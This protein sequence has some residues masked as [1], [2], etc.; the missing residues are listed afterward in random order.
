MLHVN[1]L[2]KNFLGRPILKNITYNFPSTGLIGLVGVNGAGKTTFLNILCGLD[3]PDSGTIGQTKSKTLGYLPQEVNINPKST[4]IEECMS[5]NT[6]LYQLK[7]QL[8][9][10]NLILSDCYTDEYYNKFETFENKYRNAGGYAFEANASKV[11][12]GLG[13]N[14]EQ[15]NDHPKSLSGG[16]RMRL[17]LAKVLIKNPDFLILD[18]PTNHLDLPSIIW[19]EAYLKKI[20]GTVL[21]VSHDESIL[22]RLPDRILHLKDG[23]L[24]EYYGNYDNFL[25]QYELRQLGKIAEIKHLDNKI[26]AATCFVERFKAKA[27]KARQAQSRLKMIA[28][29]QSEKSDITVDEAD[30]E[31]SIKIPLTQKSGKDVL[32]L[33]HCAIGYN[34]PLVRKIS[35]FVRR[36]QKI[37]IVGANGLGKSTLLKS[38]IGQ[39]PFVSGSMTVGHNVN[40]SYYAQD[41]F[42]YLD[43]NKTV[44]EN[45]MDININ[46]T[47]N[48]ARKVLGSFLFRS[49]DVHKHVKVLSGGEKS[50]LSL[51]CLLLKDA[52]FL[53]LDEP[54]N[55]LDILSSEVLQSA[56]SSYEGAV[57][58]VSHNRNFINHVATHVLVL[59]NKGKAQLYEGNLDSIVNYEQNIFGELK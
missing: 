54:T 52:N 9:E 31:I 5:G 27:T 30:F 11:L 32:C 8:E 17:E 55:H 29:M 23:N 42:E 47:I 45:V 34:K 28:R 3:E 6:E 16:W 2:S 56:L 19:L 18:E 46:V 35:L 51:A 41:Q 24:T 59:T 13:F 25:E 44:L 20:K 36:G 50:R 10:I 37:A 1:N 4:I 53:L 40:M 21:F 38:I 26:K 49:D 39:I 7:L 48:A 14:Q 57:M 22:N 12:T 15:L 58:F 33:E 43:L